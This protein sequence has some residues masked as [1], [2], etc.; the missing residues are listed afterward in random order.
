[1]LTDLR[2]MLLAGP[3]DREF[4]EIVQIKKINVRCLFADSGLSSDDLAEKNDLE[5][6]VEFHGPSFPVGVEHGNDL[7]RSHLE[8]AFLPHLSG[9]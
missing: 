7:D 2:D 5:G 6:V 3:I 4:R 9:H 1:M 8:P